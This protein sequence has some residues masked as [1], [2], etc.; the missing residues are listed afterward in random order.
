MPAIGRG[1]GHAPRLVGRARGNPVVLPVRRCL[2]EGAA[3]AR[4]PSQSID[5]RGLAARREN[6]PRVPHRRWT[7]KGYFARLSHRRARCGASGV[8]GHRRSR[9]L[10]HLFS[11]HSAAHPAHFDLIQP[12]V[13][14][15]GN[16]ASRQGASP[17]R[18]SLADE[19]TNIMPA[20]ILAYAQT[21]FWHEKQTRPPVQF[22]FAVRGR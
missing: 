7:S 10:A 14:L 15:Y 8:A 18:L 6:L 13:P 20:T 22:A 19:T 11:S 12:F 1:G 21:L 4:T 9:L 3:P 16:G 17:H 2:P 5:R